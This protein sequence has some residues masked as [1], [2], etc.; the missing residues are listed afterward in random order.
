MAKLTV[1][2][3]IKAAMANVT[4]LR[5]CGMKNSYRAWT[6]NRFDRGYNA[7]VESPHT[8]R[9]NAMLSRHI[10][11]VRAALEWAC[12]EFDMVIP[13]DMGKEIEQGVWA[14][15]SVRDVLKNTLPRLIPNEG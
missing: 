14:D 15:H 11:M 10:A 7:W 4:E 1:T 9:S 3:A 13:Y 5:S 6:Y 2:A 12:R 8:W